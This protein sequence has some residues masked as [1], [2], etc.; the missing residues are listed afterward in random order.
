MTAH[1]SRPIT[2]PEDDGVKTVF[3]CN[4]L[5]GRMCYAVMIPGSTCEPWFCQNVMNRGFCPLGYANPFK[6]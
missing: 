6:E 3:D 4:N 1:S 5:D 2:I